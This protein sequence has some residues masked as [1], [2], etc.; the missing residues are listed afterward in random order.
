MFYV[1]EHIRLDTNAVFYV[2]KGR[3]RRCFEAK[4]RNQ[5]WKRIVAKAGGFDVRVVVDKIDEELAFLAE[6][7]LI[8]KLKLQGAS[9]ANLTDGG[10]GVSGYR[11][12]DNA[13]IQ[14]SKTM[15]RTMET[16]KHIVRERQLGKK[17]SAKK[18]GVGDKISKALRG[19]KL[20]SE[21]KAKSS[22]P[23]GKNPR[24]VKVSLDGK[25]FG[26]IKDMAEFIGMSYTTLV[27]RMRKMKKYDWTT[28][29]MAPVNAAIAAG[30]N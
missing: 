24:A 28:E 3:G 14:F 22:L 29:D 30:K 26:C 16:Y 19:R 7:E 23:R 18:L 8:A 20:S 2:G 12:T 17:N 10:E 25:Q 13:R 15:S 6:Q 11:H 27:N 9:L 21:R 1:Y 4:R 5:H